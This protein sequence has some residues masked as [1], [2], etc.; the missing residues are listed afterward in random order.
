MTRDGWKYIVLEG[1]P[2]M[3]HNLNED[4]LEQANLA[5]NSVFHAQRRKLHE[6]LRDW[7]DRTGDTFQMPDL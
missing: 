7:I 6:T 1:Q 2:W 4:P 3:M 5:H